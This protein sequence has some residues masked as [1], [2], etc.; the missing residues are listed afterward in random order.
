M[1]F[2]GRLV[3]VEYWAVDIGLTPIF[4]LPAV[5]RLMTNFFGKFVPRR[6]SGSGNVIDAPWFIALCFC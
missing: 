4:R 1:Q 3:T 2:G 6:S 5:S